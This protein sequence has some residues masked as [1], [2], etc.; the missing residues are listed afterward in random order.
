MLQPDKLV[1]FIKSDGAINGQEEVKARPPS[2]LQKSAADDLFSQIVSD[3]ASG[4]VSRCQGIDE[5]D[6]PE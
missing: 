2:Q 1:E 3:P 6:Y 5:V 4:D